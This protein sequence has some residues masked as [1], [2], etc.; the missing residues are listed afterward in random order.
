M[1]AL[2]DTVGIALS[3][4]CD[5]ALAAAILQKHEVRTAGYTLWLTPE[6]DLRTPASIAAELGMR[7]V[8]VDARE[9][10]RAQV[11]D[12]V[13]RLYQ[14]AM[15]PNPCIMCN[16]T[17]KFPTVLAR[18]RMDGCVAVATGHY[19]RVRRGRRVSVLRARDTTRDQSYFLCLLPQRVLRKVQFPLGELSSKTRARRQR[20]FALRDRCLS[21]SRDAC[22]LGD[23]GLRGFLGDRTG[24]LSPGPIVDHGNNLL[25]KHPGAA[26]Y[27]IGQRKG[28]GLSGGPWYVLATD[29]KR[30]RVVVGTRADASER[31][32]AVGFLNWVSVPPQ[33]SRFRASVQVRSSH[34]A[35]PGVV[36]PQSRSRA[37]IEF[38]APQFGIALGQYA[39]FYDGN[40]LLG[41]GRILSRG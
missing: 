10:F 20:S 6:Q 33:I 17:V 35:A 37:V 27:T 19:A 34:R 36:H 23:A 21:P 22:F 41:G 24:S 26:L 5:S 7:H 32:L 9:A 3:G 12:R 18:A 40:V 15:T 2:E 29:V 1:T 39:V 31:R 8:V 14:R 16:A 11:V 30:N 38:D 28:L 13:L 4:G 25:G